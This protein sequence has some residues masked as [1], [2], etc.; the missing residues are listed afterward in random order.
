MSSQSVD[1]EDVSD[2]DRFPIHSKSSLAFHFMSSFGHFFEP[3]VPF[4]DLIFESKPNNLQPDNLPH[5]TR[6]SDF[7]EILR[8]RKSTRTFGKI[9][10]TLHELLDI[11]WCADGI[12]HDSPIGICRTTPSAGGLF[13]VSSLILCQ[14]V[15]NLPLAA[16]IYE[17]STSQLFEKKE[18]ILPSDLSV[19]FRTQH[20]DYSSTSAIIMWIGEIL[21]ICPKYGDRGYRY[22]L[23]ET[24]HI[25]QN[26]CLAATKLDIPHVV[27]GGF[28][29]ELCASTFQLNF[30]WE[31]VIYAMV[32]GKKIER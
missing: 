11:L 3:S 24:G 29:D 6:L 2:D 31:C 18:I 20:I 32:L 22:M 30:P 15:E 16:F 5:D 12:T 19:L 17:P 10:L 21:K 7:S 28:D 25:A 13:P 8:A 23:L 27:I 4:E 14:E 26:A 1:R 9:P